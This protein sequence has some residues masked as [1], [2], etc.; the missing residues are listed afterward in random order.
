MTRS[1]I[2]KEMM[3]KAIAITGKN[4]KNWTRDAENEIW[5]MASDWNREHYGDN[6]YPEIFM[7]EIHEEDGYDGNGFMIE[8]DYFLYE[9]D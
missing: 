9:E 8:D 6:E 1:E 7:C 5:D 3:E 2:I 4:S